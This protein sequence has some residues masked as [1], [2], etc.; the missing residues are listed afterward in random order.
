[1]WGGKTFFL[2]VEG[3]QVYE[4][5]RRAKVVT[6]QSVDDDDDDDDAT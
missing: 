4:V 1:M 5:K 2:K 6:F 3:K